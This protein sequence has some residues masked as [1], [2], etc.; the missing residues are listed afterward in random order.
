MFRDDKLINY[1]NESIII[2][3]TIVSK[4]TDVNGSLGS[5]LFRPQTFTDLLTIRNNLCL[6][7]SEKPKKT[8]VRLKAVYD[9][10]R[11][12]RT[13]GQMNEG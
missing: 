2:N 12:R 9:W 3:L 1:I 6:P 10:K 11:S 4:N 8:V 13:N 5:L 7:G